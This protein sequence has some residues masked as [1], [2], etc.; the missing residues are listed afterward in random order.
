MS[1]TYQGKPC[2]YGHSGLRYINHSSCVQCAKERAY[3]WRKKNI[4][5]FNATKYRTRVLK[6]Y[7]ITVEDVD[8]MRLSQNYK[9][10]ICGEH[11]DDAPYK[12]LCIDHCHT[13]NIV[14]G[15]LC[16]HC[17]AA[18]GHFRESTDSLQKAID[19]IKEHSYV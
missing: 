12:R 17:N 2:K 1:K 8:A 18:I 5:K 6:A 14:R 15:L 9:C 16:H 19:Y 3:E 13:T 4:D 10:K 11:E 7:G